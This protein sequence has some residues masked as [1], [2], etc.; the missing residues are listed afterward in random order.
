MAPIAKKVQAL[1]LAYV[2][3]TGKMPVKLPASAAFIQEI[4][5]LEDQLS[6]IIVKINREFAAKHNCPVSLR[7]TAFYVSGRDATTCPHGI[8]PKSTCR[9][10]RT[11]YERARTVPAQRVKRRIEVRAALAILTGDSA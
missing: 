3:R 5:L 8:K 4:K 9:A 6:S 7:R 10:C 1:Q 2:A 11:D